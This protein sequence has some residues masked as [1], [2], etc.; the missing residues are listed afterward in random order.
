M[1]YKISCKSL[2]GRIRAYDM[3]SPFELK[4]DLCQKKES[5]FWTWKQQHSSFNFWPGKPWCNTTVTDRSCTATQAAYLIIRPHTLKWLLIQLW[6]EDRS[7]ALV[8]MFSIKRSGSLALVSLWTFFPPRWNC[9]SLPVLQTC[10][11]DTRSQSQLG[12]LRGQ[13]IIS[14]CKRC[15]IF[16]FFV[17]IWISRV[18]CAWLLLTIF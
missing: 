16:M 10:V 13:S 17:L 15:A 1:V 18:T 9:V 3:R 6:K 5:H 11:R 2:A 12:V 7:N 8:L 14:H 4:S